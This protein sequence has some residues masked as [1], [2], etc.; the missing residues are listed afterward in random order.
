MTEYGVIN[1]FSGDSDFGVIEADEN[2]GNIRLKLTR[3]SG[4]GN[5]KVKTNKTIL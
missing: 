2:G 5:I 3:A 4:L 1:S